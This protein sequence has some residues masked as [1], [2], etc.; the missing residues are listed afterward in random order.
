MPMLTLTLDDTGAAFAGRTC[1]A[2]AIADILEELAE[3]L[4]AT[5]PHGLTDWPLLDTYGNRAG[6]VDL[7]ALPVKYHPAE[8]SDLEELAESEDCAWCGSP[9]LPLLSDGPGE[10]VPAWT[11]DPDEDDGGPLFC[12]AFCARRARVL[13]LDPTR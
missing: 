8:G 10:T 13:T 9:L 4:R 6:S 11:N 12:S 1:R 5:Q 7:E 3:R 2:H